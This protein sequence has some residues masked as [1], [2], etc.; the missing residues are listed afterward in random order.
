M[1]L[2]AGERNYVS[3]PYASVSGGSDNT[4]SGN[5]AAVSGGDSNKATADAASVSGGS[6]NSASGGCIDQQGNGNTA[7][8]FDT[9]VSG[10]LR[11]SEGNIGQGRVS[12]VFRRTG[13]RT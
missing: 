7:T 4:A 13:K 10:G 8:V 9:T 2:V 1:G 5:G 3:G 6:G 12:Y 11:E